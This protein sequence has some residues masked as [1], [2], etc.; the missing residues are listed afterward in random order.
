MPRA[1]QSPSSNNAEFEALAK[2]LDMVVLLLDRKTNLK[3]ASTGA[4]HL[5]GSS[6][7]DS[8]RSDWRD[9]YDR[10]NLP[11]LAKLEKNGKPLNIRT[12]LQLQESKQLLRMDIYPSA[13]TNAIVILCL[14]KTWRF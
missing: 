3:F 7:R 4:H 12:E 1:K 14:S 13:T 10:L 9:C 8:L 6:D 11:D 5:F 2:L